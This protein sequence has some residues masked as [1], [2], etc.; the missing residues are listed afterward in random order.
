MSAAD[1]LDVIVVVSQMLLATHLFTRNLARRT[2]FFARL[3]ACAVVMA[4]ATLGLWGLSKAMPL[5]DFE[6]SMRGQGVVFAL[7]PFAMTLAV[8]ACLRTSFWEALFCCTSA[9]TMQNLATGL[10]GFVRVACSQAG[11]RIDTIPFGILCPIATTATVFVPCYLLLIRRIDRAHLVGTQDRGMLLVML[12]VVL[13]TVVFDMINKVLPFFGVAIPYVLALRVVH[14][15]TCAFILFAEFEMIYNKRLVADTEALSHMVEAS[16]RQYEAS[17]ENIEAINLKCHDL[18]HQIHE[19]RDGSRKVDAQAL[20]EIERAVGIYDATVKTGNEALDTILTEKSLLCERER[21]ALT[22]IADGEALGFMA[23]SDLY[24]LFGNLLDNA[25]ESAM[26][27]ADNGRRSISLVVRKSAGMLVIHEENWAPAEIEFAGDTPIT[28]KITENG[29]RDTTSHGF[30]IRSM[31]LVADRYGGSLSVR[32]EGGTFKLDI[33]I[34][35][36]GQ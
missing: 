27:I 20:D 30:G 31:R 16:K 1:V 3:C 21:I 9:Y 35:L 7:A 6:R 10:D 15:S 13:V 24:S 23:P 18:K 25:I 32:A 28:S 12:V 17:R 36:E 29:Q 2:H 11:A 4:V 22:C 19:L 8:A 5:G 14:G 26:Q 34:P 33:L